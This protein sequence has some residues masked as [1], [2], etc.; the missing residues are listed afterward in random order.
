MQIENEGKIEIR[1]RVKNKD[2]YIYIIDSGIGMD[3][4][5]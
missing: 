1:A 4:I 5:I 3:P 2:C